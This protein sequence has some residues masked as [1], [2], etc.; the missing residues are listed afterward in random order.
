VEG[1]L[2][3]WQAFSLAFSLRLDSSGQERRL[4]IGAQLKKLP[5]RNVV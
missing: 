1:R 4:K 5:H 3:L 2:L